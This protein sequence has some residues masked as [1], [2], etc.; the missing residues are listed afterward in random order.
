MTSFFSQVRLHLVDGRRAGQGS[1]AVLKE[2]L[3]EASGIYVWTRR[4]DD[5]T[6]GLTPQQRLRA[7]QARLQTTRDKRPEAGRLGRYRRVQIFDDPSPLTSSS[8]ARLDK[9]VSAGASELSWI[10]L[11][12]SLFQR[13]LYVGKAL[14]FKNRIPAHF[15]YET[16]FAKDLQADGFDINDC[17]VTLLAIMHPPDGLTLHP[18]GTKGD[19]TDLQISLAESLV[20]RAAQPVYNV[21]M[22]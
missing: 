14:N 3:P 16:R 4:V 19:E 13:P 17:L 21:R 8:H 20:I 5:D 11:A 9:L 6:T 1:I 10:L 15:N 18:P 22:D 7:M 12:T 2:S